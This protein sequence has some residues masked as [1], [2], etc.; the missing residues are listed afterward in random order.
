L[1]PDN[2]FLWRRYSDNDESVFSENSHF[3][4][5]ILVFGAIGMNYK[6]P[7]IVTHGSINANDYIEILK[8]ARLFSVL[9][10]TKGRDNYVFQQ[11]GAKCH[12]SKKTLK[13]LK[14]HT[15]FICKWPS[16]SPDFNPIEMCWAILKHFVKEHHPET[17]TELENLVQESWASIPFSTINVLVKS[18]RYRLELATIV[19]G[20][21][22]ADWIRKGVPDY[23][24]IPLNKIPENVKLL[25]PWVEDIVF[26][27]DED[28]DISDD[29][30]D[31]EPMIVVADILGEKRPLYEKIFTVPVL[32]VGPTP[33]S[34]HRSP[35]LPIPRTNR[36]ASKTIIENTTTT[37]EYI[38]ICGICGIKIR[39]PEMHRRTNMH[40]NATQCSA[41]SVFDYISEK[42]ENSVINESPGLEESDI[43][44]LLR[45]IGQWI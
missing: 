19:Q 32:F 34:Y 2:R 26:D 16:N 15:R 13:Y 44:R 4:P 38:N 21:S 12:T 1:G 24:N 45:H 27:G 3:P 6:S 14:K 17:I 37:K 39:D 18:F 28:E 5:G 11:D 31:P 36:S 30:P 29:V 22:I 9:E 10:N 42:M 8:K 7:L 20:E 25:E 33:Q 40:I 23:I 43:D 35:F 41:W